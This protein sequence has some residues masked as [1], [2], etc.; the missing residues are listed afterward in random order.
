ME[1][2]KKLL[3]RSKDASITGKVA[4]ST[5]LVVDQV[6]FGLETSLILRRSRVARVGESA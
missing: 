5:V 1:K 4:I 2:I 6:N 3:I